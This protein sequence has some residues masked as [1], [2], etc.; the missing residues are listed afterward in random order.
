MTVHL[1][2]F[3]KLHYNYAIPGHMVT[4]SDIAVLQYIQAF[5]LA[6]QLYQALP[7]P[8]SVT[9]RFLML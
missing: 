4:W 3:R 5:L 6:P 2:L 9:F 1:P 7:P 8:Y